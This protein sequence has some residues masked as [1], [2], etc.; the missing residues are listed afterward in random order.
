MELTEKLTLEQGCNK[1][2]LEK[3][4]KV[5]LQVQRLTDAI[6]IKDRELSFLRETTSEL[7]KQVLQH[8][9]LADRLRHYEAQDNSS[10]ILQFELQ[11]AKKT[12]VKLANEVNILKSEK[13]NPSTQDNGNVSSPL[14]N[15]ND[16]QINDNEAS[17][18]ELSYDKKDLADNDNN[19]ISNTTLHD[20][21]LDKESA[22][23]HLE[24]KFKK[25]MQ[26]IADL[27]E[28]KQRLEHLVLQLQGETE[29]IGE[30][31]ALYQHQR[32][33]LKQ[34]A[35]EKD[36]QLKQLANDREQIKSKLEK[37]NELITKLVIEKGQV[38]S[39]LLQ[40][41]KSL[42]DQSEKFCEEHAK[43]HQQINEIND[44][45]PSEHA[46]E[47]KSETAREIIELLSDIKNS[48]LIQN[49]E[50]FHHCPWCSGK[51]ITV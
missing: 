23:K 15:K 38:P 36:Q 50:D 39:E 29:T 27:T 16:E 40:Q 5:E 20:N 1:E 2:L 14:N 22:M 49:E 21:G 7:S 33:I 51:L 34:K 28:E 48:N 42:N 30:Y 13:S 41:H 37:L 12:I 4:Q 35:I 32:M 17:L 44:N 46:A 31:V 6:E 47:E 11:E 26:E 3:L 43:L 9:Q 25:T 19:N 18:Q 45:N 24:E 8:E 10:H